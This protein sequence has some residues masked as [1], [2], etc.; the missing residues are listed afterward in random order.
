MESIE[1]IVS[2]QD[3]WIDSFINITNHILFNPVNTL[4]LG[5]AIATG[6]LVLIVSLVIV[7]KISSGES[8]RWGVSF[9]MVPCIIAILLLTASALP[10]FLHPKI[11]QGNLRYIAD[12]FILAFL[13]LGPCMMIDALAFKCKYFHSLISWLVSIVIT[14]CAILGI[15]LLFSGHEAPPTLDDVKQ[16]SEE[17]GS[18]V[19]EQLPE[20]KEKLEKIPGE[21]KDKLEEITEKAKPEEAPTTTE[22]N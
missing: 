7:H 22:D 9:F 14:V 12:I 5:L 8:F 17:M 1:E 21:M 2:K 19:K 4:H 3:E 11:S 13:F 18:K 6:L 20:V 16:I 10:V 15:S